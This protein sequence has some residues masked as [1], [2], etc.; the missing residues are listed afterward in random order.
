MTRHC[1]DHGDEAVGAT[2]N[3]EI[4][5]WDL[6][7]PEYS[8]NRCDPMRDGVANGAGDSKARNGGPKRIAHRMHCFRSQGQPGQLSRRESFSRP[9]AAAPHPQ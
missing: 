5:L 2:F 8:V 4:F 6:E 9:R 3:H 7:A 1:L